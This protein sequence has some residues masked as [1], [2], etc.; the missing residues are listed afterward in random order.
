MLCIGR[1]E[2]E[3]PGSEG[4]KEG[5]D[6][7]GGRR[8]VGKTLRFREQSVGSEALSPLDAVSPDS[9][10]EVVRPV[11]NDERVLAEAS[12]TRS[13]GLPMPDASRR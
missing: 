13:L 9:A 6:R 12:E 2:A 4:T 11:P 3:G 10:D 5:W 8:A 7:L 1:R